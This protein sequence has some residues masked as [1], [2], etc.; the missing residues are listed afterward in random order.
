[1]SAACR[2]RAD[3]PRD[4]KRAMTKRACLI[5][6]LLALAGP[7]WAQQNDDAAACNSETADPDA[8]IQSCSRA[9]KSGDL[10]REDLAVA[11]GNRG[12]AH[13]GKRQYD[14][15][16]LDFDQAI[17]LRPDAAAYYSR[18]KAYYRNDQYD[19]AILD[20]GQAISL[21]PD[22]AAYY[23]RAK[24]HNKK[25][26][27]D[28]AIQD[29]GQAIKLKPEAKTYFYRG[30]AHHKKG[31]SDAAIQDFDQAIGLKPDFA[32]AYNVRAWIRYLLGDNDAALSDVDKARSLSPNN[33]AVI[34]NRA[35][36]LAALKRPQEAL[37]AFERTI[38]VGGT[39]VA[40][41]YQ[42]ALKAQDYDPGPVD[43]QYGKA[44][45]RALLACLKAGCRLLE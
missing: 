43:G 27:Y 44:T 10:S 38:K 34:N 21:K 7:A 35:H 33:A 6:L 24:A 19:P 11:Y 29:Y 28:P 40:K 41:L 13:Y 26:E 31:Q 23:Y 25:G 20:F 30:N 22:A 18:G 8:K 16:I 9:I 15:A 45:R 17:S 37:A 14:Q 3:G 42:A 5:F 12:Q 2:L 39:Q 32:A 1:L 36:I 4:G